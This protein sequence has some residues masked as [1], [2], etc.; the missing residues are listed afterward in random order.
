VGNQEWSLKSF[1]PLDDLFAMVCLPLGSR[2]IQ[3]LFSLGGHA[4]AFSI[5]QTWREFFD[6]L[7]PIHSAVDSILSRSLCSF[8]NVVNLAFGP[9]KCFKIL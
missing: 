6:V 2:L 1:L 5:L 7:S 3:V 9:E 8:V 4:P